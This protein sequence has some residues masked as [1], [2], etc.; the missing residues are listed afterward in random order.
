MPAG[1]PHTEAITQTMAHHTTNNIDLQPLWQQLEINGCTI[2][3]RVAVSAIATGHDPQ[4]YAAYLGARARGGAGLIVTGAQSV[5]PSGDIGWFRAWEPDSEETYRLLAAAVHQH[6]GKLFG[7][8][9]HCGAQQTG[10]VKLDTAGALIAASA[11][12]SPVFTT[13]PTEATV[14]EI[15][16]MVEAFADAAARMR[17]GGLDGVEVHAAHGY[18][19]HSFLSP[20]ANRRNDEYGGDP[21]RRARIVVEVG[22]AVRARCGDHYPIGVKLSFDEFVGDQGITVPVATETLEILHAEGIFDYVSV[23]GTSYHSLH[24]WITSMESG[25]SGHLAVHSAAAKRVVGDL[26]VMVTGA[27]HSVAEAA[28]IVAA[29]EADVVGMVRAQLADPDLVRK[30]RSGQQATIRPCVG[31]NQ[32][33]WRRYFRGGQV[34]CTVN[35]EVGREKM[36]GDDYF[37]PTSNPMRV[38][39]IGGGPAGLKAAES[40]ARRGHDVLVLELHDQLGGQ[41]HFAGRLPGRERWQRLIDHLYGEVTRLGVEVRLGTRAT[42]ELVEQIDPDLTVV[43]TGASWD[44]DGSSAMLGRLDG[45]TGLNYANVLTPIEAIANPD[46]CGTKVMLVDEHGT[47]AALGLAQL[48]TRHG[49]S[50]TFV[51]AQHHPGSQTLGVSTL[52]HPWVY[53]EL[54]KAGVEFISESVIDRVMPGSVVVGSLYDARSREVEDVDSIVLCMGRTSNAD[55]YRALR[56][57]GRAVECIGDALAPREVDEAI[58]EGAQ[59][60][61]SLRAEDLSRGRRAVR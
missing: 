40:S 14:Q 35:P 7:Q 37:A 43:A 44:T 31:A 60:A 18:L 39:V 36:W 23:S 30:A 27:V 54:V 9:H 46:A 49:C 24:E 12:A 10:S 19:L 53:P 55:L 32:G 4:Q 3:N 5:H 6:D 11:L 17:R 47:H 28:R 20:M 41:L 58:L 15:G 8:L 52:N 56:Q 16:E 1:S 2:A 51:T 22:R 26:P 25:R 34:S 57:R 29:S 42:E 33:C 48:L 45:I 21:L 50:V 61:R 59:S 38:L 13:A